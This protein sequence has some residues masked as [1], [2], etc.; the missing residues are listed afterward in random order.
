M[1]GKRFRRISVDF[2]LC[3]SVRWPRAPQ[4]NYLRMGNRAINGIE[5]NSILNKNKDPGKQRK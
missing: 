5:F 1:E 3:N 2:C 4:V